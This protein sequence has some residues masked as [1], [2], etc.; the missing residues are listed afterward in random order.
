MGPGVASVKIGA[1][2]KV[3]SVGSLGDSSFFPR[4]AQ[5]L[6]P[7]FADDG[8]LLSVDALRRIEE[9]RPICLPLAS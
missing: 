3:A 1:E 2:M 8:V 7:S 5:K 6:E 9:N 4:R